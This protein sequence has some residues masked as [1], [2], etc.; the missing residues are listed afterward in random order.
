MNDRSTLVALRP[1]AGAT[2]QVWA[3]HI[4]TCWRASFE[5]I[6]ETGH[7]LIAA[8]EALGHGHFEEMVET[9]LPFKMNTAQRLMAISRDERITNAAYATLLPPV[10]TVLYDLTKLKTPQFTE[11]V[12]EGVIRPDMGAKEIR[13]RIKKI[14]RAT[15]EQELG[16]KQ[17]SLP[18][19]KYGII[20]AD[21]EWRFEPWSRNTGMDRAADNHYPTSCTEVIASRAVESIAADDC[22]LFLW[23]TVPML[24]HALIV[25]AAWGFDYRSQFVWVKDRVGTGYWARNQHELLLIGVRGDPPAPEAGT[26][27]RSVIQAPVGQHS[28]KPEIILEYIDGWY[29]TFPKIELNRRGPARQGWDAWGNESSDRIADESGTNHQPNNVP[30]L[31]LPGMAP[32]WETIAAFVDLTPT[33]AANGS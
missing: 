27:E 24:P 11:A 6:L 13:Q 32:T 28:Q 12:G 2:A 16:E 21:P 5:G 14:R 7:L 31:I 33:Q 19:R 15:R 10:W 4:T 26:R 8:K 1:P 25:M 30:E 29:P 18:D 17:N 3:N 22:V 23:A 20:L 9:D